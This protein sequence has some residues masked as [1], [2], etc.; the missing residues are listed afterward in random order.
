M[1]ERRIRVR[2]RVY[3]ITWFGGWASQCICLLGLEEGPNDR[4]WHRVRYLVQPIVTEEDL[5][6]DDEFII[7]KILYLSAFVEVKAK[8]EEFIFKV[9]NIIP[10]RVHLAW[11]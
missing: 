6:N 11:Y 9:N 10:G 3:G 1:E 8:S 2:V 4:E 5:E 7:K